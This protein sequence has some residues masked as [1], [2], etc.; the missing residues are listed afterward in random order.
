MARKTKT[1]KKSGGKIGLDFTGVETRIL[2]PE[3]DYLL[4]VTSLTEEDESV[5]VGLTLMNGKFEGKAV[6]EYFSTKPQALWRFGNFI[7]ACGLQV[8]NG[9][10]ELDVHS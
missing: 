5:I 8:P 6:K 10:V 9:E 1:T 2:L 4:S 3:N 7:A